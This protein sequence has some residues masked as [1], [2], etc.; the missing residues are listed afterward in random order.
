[1]VL[2]LVLLVTY[3]IGYFATSRLVKGPASFPTRN[4]YL[5]FNTSDLSARLFTYD[6][7]T[8]IYTPAARV[9]SMLSGLEV[10]VHTLPYSLD[11]L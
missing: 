10:E 1:M 9:E 5:M 4:G 3:V 7:Q 2:C 8:T 11:E 6:W